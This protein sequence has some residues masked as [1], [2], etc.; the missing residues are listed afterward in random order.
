MDKHAGVYRD[1]A[2]MREGLERIGEL[3]QRFRKIGI[4]DKSRVYNSNLMQALETE[5]MLDL[6]E[7]LLTSGWRARNRAERTRGPI[8]PSATMRSSW[9]IR[10]RTTPAEGRGWSISR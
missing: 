6:A 2:S 4:Q 7:A 8:S 3:K 10:W 1:G 9:A 5:N